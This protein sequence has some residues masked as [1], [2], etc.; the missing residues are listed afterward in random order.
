MLEYEIFLV[1]ITNILR[2]L[3]VVSAIVAV[4]VLVDY[5]RNWRI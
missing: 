3:T 5:Y 2:L 1:E 4:V